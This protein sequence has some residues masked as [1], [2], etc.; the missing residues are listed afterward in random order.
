[1]KS[2]V[3]EL[4]D[5]LIAIWALVEDWNSWW[6]GQHSRMLAS[7]WVPELKSAEHHHDPEGIQDLE[8]PWPGRHTGVGATMT[9][10]AYRTWSGGI[11]IQ[12]TSHRFIFHKQLWFTSRGHNNKITTA[13]KHCRGVRECVCTYVCTYCVPHMIWWVKHVI[14]VAYFER[15]FWLQSDKACRKELGRK[16]Y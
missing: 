16:T 2:C 9:W 11:R 5:I 7:T 4:W 3:G 10:K 13:C 14:T 6:I 12:S 8:P 1:M 15:F